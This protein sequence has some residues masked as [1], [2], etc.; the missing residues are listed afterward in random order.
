MIE[1]TLPKSYSLLLGSVRLLKKEGTE[2]SKEGLSKLVRGI[3]DPETAPYSHLPL[4]GYCPS[5]SR[6]KVKLRLSY[7]IKTGYL[8]TKPFKEGNEEALCLT[9]EGEKASSIRFTVSRS[10]KRL[11]KTIELCERKEK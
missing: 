11:D 9:E 4:F 1:K 7:L 5:L 8:V 10:T 3:Y 6:K 2:A